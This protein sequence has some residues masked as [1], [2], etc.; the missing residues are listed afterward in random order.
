MSFDKGDYEAILDKLAGLGDEKYKEFNESLIPG[1][2]TAYGVRVPALR[3]IARHIIKNDPQNF[4]VASEEKISAG[5]SFEEI[6]LRG[7]VIGGMKLEIESRIELI[8]EFL[9]LIDN[10][11]V[12]DTF[13]GSFKL[14][15]PEEK[16]AMWDFISPLFFDSREYFARFALV[17]FLGKFIEEPY[18]QEGL[19]FIERLPQEQYYVR[20]A[21]AWAV[22]VCY[23]KFPS[24]TK[25]LLVRRSL[26]KFTQNK[27]I[28]K[29]RESY[30]VAKEDKEMLLAFKLPPR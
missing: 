23:V 24:E 14:K 27:A 5:G 2:S 10:W 25:V 16:A 3:E 9:P 18:V 6:M 20:M 8:R 12:C 21:A 28:Q 22:S 17:M 29:I 19:G 26:P 7:L 13:C 15:G 1:K 30:R 11:A 4:L